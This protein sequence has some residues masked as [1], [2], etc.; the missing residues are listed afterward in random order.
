M[1]SRDSKLV[2]IIRTSKFN[3]YSQLFLKVNRI[4]YV[5]AQLYDEYQSKIGHNPELFTDL[6]EEALREAV[7]YLDKS[8]QVLRSIKSEADQCKSKARS[9]GFQSADARSRMSVAMQHYVTIEKDWEALSGLA[10]ALERSGS[11]GQEKIVSNDI[12]NLL[13]DIS[14]KASKAISIL[15]DLRTKGLDQL[16]I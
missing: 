7:E 15:S 2:A 8:I 10:D 12:Q 9:A 1:T 14:D 3:R 5:D 16:G 11:E 4:A 6:A 13:G